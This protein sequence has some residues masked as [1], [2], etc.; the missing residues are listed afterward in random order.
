MDSKGN[1]LLSLQGRKKKDGGLFE[2]V[3]LHIK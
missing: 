1:I 3:G 2:A